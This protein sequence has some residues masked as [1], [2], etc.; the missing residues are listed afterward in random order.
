MANIEPAIKALMIESGKENLFIREK[1]EKC[2]QTIVQGKLS[3][4]PDKLDL[5]MCE[6]N[7]I[8]AIQKLLSTLYS[9]TKSKNSTTRV[10]TAQFIEQ[11]VLHTKPDRCLSD[12]RDITDKLMNAMINAVNDSASD[13]RYFG[14]RIVHHL[15]DHDNFEKRCKQYLNN[16]DIKRIN[17]I[18]NESKE[19]LHSKSIT[20][21][22][23]SQF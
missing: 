13:A 11:A 1:C 2:F 3:F 8:G 5:V 21:L 18:R 23:V 9:H 19:S 15:A 12:T 7:Q 10:I 16:E 22:K 14:R 20:K 6:S 4:M 17:L